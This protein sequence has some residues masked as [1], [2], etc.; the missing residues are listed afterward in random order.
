MS[1][2][3]VMFG[4]TAFGSPLSFRLA[5]WF[6]RGGWPPKSRTA[7]TRACLFF[8]PFPTFFPSRFAW[9][10]CV[11]S[12]WEGPWP[13]V[14]LCAWFFPGGVD[15][16]SQNA[17]GAWNFGFVR[18]GSVAPVG[19]GGDDLWASLLVWALCGRTRREGF[20][21]ALERSRFLTRDLRINLSFCRVFY[22][23][24]FVRGLFRVQCDSQHA[25]FH[26]PGAGILG[27]RWNGRP[28]DQPV[29]DHAYRQAL[30][31]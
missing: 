14:Q 22:S 27:D 19:F 30:D 21:A 18:M 12:S 4:R 15:P 13:L 24:R 1:G 2:A 3:R 17:H 5:L 26:S 7:G 20:L 23:L 28:G 11:S 9:C 10:V 16:L 29:W 25:H 8:F 31:A 6:F